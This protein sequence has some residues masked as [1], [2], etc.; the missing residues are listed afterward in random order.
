MDYCMECGNLDCPS[1]SEAP[2]WRTCPASWPAP[3][4]DDAGDWRADYEARVY[5]RAERTTEPERDLSNPSPDPDA[6]LNRIRNL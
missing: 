1:V 6:E 4:A 5:G 3:G 2:A